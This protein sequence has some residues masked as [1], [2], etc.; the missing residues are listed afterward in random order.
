MLGP[1]NV[2]DLTQMSLVHENVSNLDKMLLT[3]RSMNNILGYE[4]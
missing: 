2:H 4:L 3:Y 1:V